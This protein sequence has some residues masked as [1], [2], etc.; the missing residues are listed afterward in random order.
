M[1]KTSWIKIR[2]DEAEKRA[3]EEV[4]DRAGIS[5]S[6]WMRERL[7]RAAIREL[8]EAGYPIPFLKPGR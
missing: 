3:F 1:Q 4:A 6:A 2:V 8:E 5:L 7:R